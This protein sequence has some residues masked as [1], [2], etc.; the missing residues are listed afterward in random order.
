MAIFP[1]SALISRLFQ[2]L[3]VFVSND[4]PANLWP[5]QKSDI[6][7]IIGSATSFETPEVMLNN[8]RGAPHRTTSDPRPLFSVILAVS[9]QRGFVCTVFRYLTSRILG[10]LSFGEFLVR[11][12][13]FCGANSL[14]GKRRYSEG[15]FYNRFLFFFW[16]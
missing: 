7:R 12:A 9:V 4:N 8:D 14:Q 1:T 6:N 5:R 13:V 3:S 10:A 16:K 2:A 15:F 11:W